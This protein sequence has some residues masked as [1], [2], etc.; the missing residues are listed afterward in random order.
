VEGPRLKKR[1]ISIFHVWPLEQK[2]KSVKEL[3]KFKFAGE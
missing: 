2:V 1:E 3:E